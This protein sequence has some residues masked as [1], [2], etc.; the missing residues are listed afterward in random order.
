MTGTRIH[1]KFVRP[2]GEGAQGTVWLAEATGDMLRRPVAIK[3]LIHDAIGTGPARRLRDEARALNLLDHRV[4]VMVQDVLEFTDVPGREGPCWGIVL[5]YVPGRDLAQLTERGAIDL[6]TLAEIGAELAEGLAHV[7]ERGIVHRDV[8]PSNVRLRAD[9]D[10]KLLDFGIARGSYEGREV[11]SVNILTGTRGFI[12]PEVFESLT[13]APPVDVF[14]LGMTL[15]AAATRTAEW[16]LPRTTRT[17]REWLAA[18]LEPDPR[19]WESLLRRMVADEPDDR[20]HAR[21]AADALRAMAPML[22]GLDR[23]RWARQ[24]LTQP[25]GSAPVVAAPDPAA[26]EA[27]DT[28]V[29]AVPTPEPQVP[30]TPGPEIPVPDIPEVPLPEQ[31]TPAPLAP[32]APAEEPP[33]PVPWGSLGWI[34][35]AAAILVVI[36]GAGAAPSLLQR[37][38]P[39]P[40]TA[41]PDADAPPTTGDSTATSAPPTPTP[42]EPTPPP[43]V[44][45]P[46]AAPTRPPAAAATP[47]AA[48]SVTPPTSPRSSTTAPSTGDSPEPSP[49][50][51]GASPPSPLA[52]VL[53]AATAPRPIS[54][55]LDGTMARFPPNG[56]W[57]PSVSPGDHHLVVTYE[58]LT[59][60]S[61][62]FHVDANE[63]LTITC[64]RTN[65]CT[66]PGGP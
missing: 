63:T 10:V 15:L 49:P 25:D 43:A 9:G 41:S 26:P 34:L 54:T 8:K 17:R 57:A 29:P 18:H 11:R 22:P 32:E 46:A 30:E 65:C 27:A 28:P 66:A 23:F 3:L 5:Q 58:G 52:T 21:Q 48:V 47:R 20:P 40:R 31:P 24:N 6:R 51:A 13:Y 45:P 53:V 64:Q 62:P 38:L 12:A 42:A 36:V 44:L 61:L 55:T 16:D 1:Y 4:I 35:A 39:P 56:T 33:P 7:H 60:P 19:P 2:L 50:A 14:A 37:L 59:C